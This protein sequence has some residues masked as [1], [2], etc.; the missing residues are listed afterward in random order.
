MDPLTAL[1]ILT[2]FAM[3]CVT[4]IVL[5]IA[6]NP[7]VSVEAIKILAGTSTKLV[8]LGNLFRQKPPQD[9]DSG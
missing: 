5:A 4:A 9:P 7:K 8:E 2:M 3:L 6:A 1:T